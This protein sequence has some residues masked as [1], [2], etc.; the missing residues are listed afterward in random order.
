MVRMKKKI[1]LQKPH[2]ATNFNG[3]YFNALLLKMSGENVDV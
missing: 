3:L 1:T 2:V